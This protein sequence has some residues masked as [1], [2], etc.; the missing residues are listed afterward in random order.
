MRD[1]LRFFGR[2]EPGRDILFST[3]AA[4]TVSTAVICRAQGNSSNGQTFSEFAG[5][6]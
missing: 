3:T 4:L 5:K 1:E 2:F 6:G